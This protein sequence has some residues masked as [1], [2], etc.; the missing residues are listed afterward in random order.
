[1]FRVDPNLRALVPAAIRSSNTVRAYCFDAQ[2]MQGSLHVNKAKSVWG[3]GLRDNRAPMFLSY[4]S[5]Q[6]GLQGKDQSKQDTARWLF[7]RALSWAPGAFSA[8]KW[9]QEKSRNG[10]FSDQVSHYSSRDRVKSSFFS[11]NLQLALLRDWPLAAF[12]SSDAQRQP[13]PQGCKPA[14]FRFL[15]ERGKVGSG[16]ET[17]RTFKD[18]SG[19]SPPFFRVACKA[20]GCVSPAPFVNEQLVETVGSHVE[21]P[22]CPTSEDDTSDTITVSSTYRRPYGLLCCLFSYH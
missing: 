7:P 21:I 3:V 22:L 18:T 4:S 15:S 16:G 2:E 5:S 6:R 8:G 20:S 1:M 9:E 14:R 17:Q 12:P 11:A 19:R 13:A 10:G